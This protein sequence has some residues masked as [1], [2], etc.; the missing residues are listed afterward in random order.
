MSDEGGVEDDEDES[1]AAEEEME[2]NDE[3]KRD[4]HIHDH[5]SALPEHLLDCEPPRQTTM[6]DLMKKI[7]EL[8]EKLDGASY[9]LLNME[10]AM[11]F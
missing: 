5:A 4:D 7:E 10:Q 8:Q 11:I 2:R 1:S 9:D 6:D 3:E